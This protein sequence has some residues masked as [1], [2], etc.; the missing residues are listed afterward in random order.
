M[1]VASASSIASHT[2]V[3]CAWNIWEDKFWNMWMMGWRYLG[4]IHDF[5]IGWFFPV[6]W[7][8]INPTCQL[9]VSM[10]CS[11]MIWDF[12]AQRCTSAGPSNIGEGHGSEAKSLQGRKTITFN[13][14][15]GL[16]FSLALQLSQKVSGDSDLTW[17]SISAYK[18][19]IWYNIGKG[20]SLFLQVLMAA[21]ISE[22]SSLYWWQFDS[23]PLSAPS[24]IKAA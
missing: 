23:F 20:N 4:F 7:L 6:G 18:Y 17:R 13:A 11:R 19:Y 3:I 21:L 5:Q 9:I 10:K 24:F 16:L 15:D 14:R 1:S 8:P 2:I 22:E 12:F